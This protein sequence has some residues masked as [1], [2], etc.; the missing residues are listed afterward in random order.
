MQQ[1]KTTSVVIVV[2]A[3]RRNLR[4]AS[5]T[6]TGTPRHVA[7]AVPSQWCVLGSEGHGAARVENQES[8]PVLEMYWP[9]LEMLRADIIV[10]EISGGQNDIFLLFRRFP[11]FRV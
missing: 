2:I 3:T 10:T 1:W 4:C 6:V 8:V 9:V 11:T 5:T 7:T